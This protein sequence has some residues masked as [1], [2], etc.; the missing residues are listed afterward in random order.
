MFSVNE[1]ES[2]SKRK[3]E[4]KPSIDVRG[5]RLEQAI[6][7]VTRFVDD[8]LMVGA[9]E[10]KILH[11]KGN[12]ILREELRKYIKTIGGVISVR[13]EHIEMGGSGITIVTLET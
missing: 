4:F 2:I 10:I 6:D 11:G 5:E 1:S 9:S 12:G 13:D 3:L 8:A 7:I